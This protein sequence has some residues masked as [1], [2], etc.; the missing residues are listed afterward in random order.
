MK[1]SPISNFK[2][3]KSNLGNYYN[4][5]STIIDSLIDIRVE[6]ASTSKLLFILRKNVIP[7][8][9]ID[10]TVSHYLPIMKKMTSSN[11][12]F[13]S[14]NKERE[15]RE[16]YERSTP[17]HSTIAGFIDSPNNKYPCRLTQ[18]SKIHFDTYQKGINMIKKV[19]DTFKETLPINYENQL[20]FANKT[21]YRID[22]T[23]FTTMTI[24]YNFQTALHVDK[25]DCTEGFGTLVIA[26]DNIEGGH[27]LFPR[28]DIGVAVHKGDILFMDVHEYHCNSAIG[29][30]NE[31]AYRM[32]FVLYLR[33]RLLDCSHNSILEALGIEEGKHW[34]TELL[35]A[36]IL[37]KISL[38]TYPRENKSDWE[39]QN[40]RYIIVCK[41][42]Q[43]KLYDRGSKKQIISLHKIWKY[44][45][46]TA[47]L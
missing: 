41:K 2:D 12:G 17:V 38:H 4:T 36:K 15:Q 22:G 46:I 45:E 34:D 21:K 44:L 24:N 3:F 16:K 11:R 28:F 7:H 25:G 35:V 27:L 9:Y 29:F 1:V 32:S 30:I 33:N 8:E 43:Y 39:L 31:D 13:A 20:A 42:R 14:G 18:F 47:N 10:N 37:E 6:D 23:A 5:A 19:N 40:D 26:S